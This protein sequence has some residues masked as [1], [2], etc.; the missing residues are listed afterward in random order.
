MEHYLAEFLGFIAPS[1]ALKFL[2]I[3]SHHATPLDQVIEVAR[4]LLAPFG[5]LLY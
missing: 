4:N 5:L 3:N 1:K 2:F